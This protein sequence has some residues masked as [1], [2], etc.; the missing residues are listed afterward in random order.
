MHAWP[1]PPAVK[2]A[3]SRHGYARPGQACMHQHR[4][5]FP[6]AFHT[7]LYHTCPVNRQAKEDARMAQF[8]AL[9]SQGPITIAK[10]QPPPGS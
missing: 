8:K 2:D 4:D 10:R 6:P 3:Q 7:I 5:L 1:N 9:L